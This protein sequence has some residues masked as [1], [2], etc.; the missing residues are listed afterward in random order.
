MARRLGGMGGGTMVSFSVH[1]DGPLKAPS[2]PSV[3]LLRSLISLK[4][5][6]SLRSSFGSSSINE[7]AVLDKQTLG[8]TV[9]TPPRSWSAEQVSSPSPAL[10]F[11]LL[12]FLATFAFTGT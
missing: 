4:S 12:E 7:A 11:F 2:Q 8:F 10:C 5:F 9:K 1:G 6:A 3:S